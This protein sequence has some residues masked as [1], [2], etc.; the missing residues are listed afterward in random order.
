[1]LL[2]IKDYFW[3]ILIVLVAGASFGLGRLT[4]IEDAR[5]PIK[6][7]SVG[8][9][10]GASNLQPA[11]PAGGPPTSNL[12]QAGKYV[13]S[14]NGTKYHLPWCSGAQRIKDENKVWFDSKTAA[15]AAGYT[16]AGN[17]PG[18]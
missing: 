10:K 11:S 7:E 8:E 1:M 6:I 4:K 15:E 9:V 5:E 12:Q 17:C 2:K 18:I 16:P 14:K 3:I 13:A